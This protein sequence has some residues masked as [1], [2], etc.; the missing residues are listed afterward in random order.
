MQ[1]DELERLRSTLKSRLQ[2]KYAI[3]GN[4]LIVT[5]TMELLMHENPQLCGDALV[6]LYVTAT[7]GWVHGPFLSV[8]RL[9]D[10]YNKQLTELCPTWMH[11]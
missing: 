9:T 7:V 10:A 8:C 4:G 1:Y 6:E 11:V 5:P 3:T 2:D